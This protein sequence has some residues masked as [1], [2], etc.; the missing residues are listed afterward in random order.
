MGFS[1]TEYLDRL[2]EAGVPE[3]QARAHLFIV[4][5]EL[6]RQSDVANVYERI[7]ILRKETK[8]NITELKKDIAE[9]KK[10]IVEIKKD[11]VEIKLSLAKIDSRITYK[12]A[13]VVALMVGLLKLLDIFI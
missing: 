13:G 5:N 10:D 9:V 2:E 6:A 1:A 8:E 7:E 11:I 12:V 4:E 3:K